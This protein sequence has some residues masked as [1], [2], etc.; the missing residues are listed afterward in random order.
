MIRE[1]WLEQLHQMFHL[2]HCLDQSKY[3]SLLLFQGYLVC[4]VPNLQLLQ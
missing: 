2:V 4:W 1:K 3:G